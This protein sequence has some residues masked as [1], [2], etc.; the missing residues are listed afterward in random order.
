MPDVAGC[1]PCTDGRSHRNAVS[2]NVDTAIAWS[3]RI[4]G[5]G[6]AGRA[7]FQ[8]RRA[9]SRA[10]ERSRIGVSSHRSVSTV[11]RRR[12]SCPRHG[13]PRCRACSQNRPAHHGNGDTAAPTRATLSG[14]ASRRRFSAW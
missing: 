5:R 13:K 14:R 2:G 3:R 12:A 10:P 6:T 4:Q 8:R 7:R 11:S 1:L 9:L